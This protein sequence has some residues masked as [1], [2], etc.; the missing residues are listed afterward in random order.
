LKFF[1]FAMKFLAWDHL[2]VDNMCVKFQGQKIHTKEVIQ[3]LPTCVVL[4][5]IS[6]LPTLIL[7]WGLKYCLFTM[8]FLS[9]NHFF[10]DNMYAKF[11]VQKICPKKDI[12][13]LPTCVVVRMNSLRPTLPPSQGLCNCH[14]TI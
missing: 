8:K 3:N 9:W 5:T 12:Q 10:V 6:L 4:E 14:L 7:S 11:L 1:S 13:N 2:Y